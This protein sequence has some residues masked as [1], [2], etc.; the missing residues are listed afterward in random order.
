[1]KL[2]YKILGLLLILSAFFVTNTVNANETNTK[3]KNALRILDS[4]KEKLEKENDTKIKLSNENIN[5]FDGK[6]YKKNNI[7]Y[8]INNIS[9]IIFDSNGNLLNMDR[10][11]E[12]KLDNNNNSSISFNN[13]KKKNIITEITKLIPD[14]FRLKEEQDLLDGVGTKLIFSNDT[15]NIENKYN[16]IIVSIENS[17]GRIITYSKIEEFN[18]RVLA[19]ITIQEA[20]NIADGY[21]HKNNVK[22]NFVKIKFVID[23]LKEDEKP[24]LI[25]KVIYDNEFEVWVDAK[26]G[27]VLLINGVKSLDGKSFYVSETFEPEN[28][29]NLREILSILGYSTSVNYF[30]SSTVKAYLKGHNSYGFTFSGHGSTNSI[31]DNSGNYVYPSNVSGKWKFVFLDACSTAAN[32]TWSNAFQ[33]YNNSS[34]MIFMGWFKDVHIKVSNKFCK[35]LNRYVKRNSS[36]SFYSNIWNALNATDDYYPLRFRGDKSWNGKI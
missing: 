20:K 13:I 6:L 30:S 16:V 14:G 33:I 7:I 26:D 34:K 10:T 12:L 31:T 2:K 28:A 22:A 23:K 5:G 19:N 21:L 8:K 35:N 24:K 9:E 32:N 18:K 3:I 17:T 15:D 4:T 11:S 29:V 1:M 25:Y 36:I 27:R